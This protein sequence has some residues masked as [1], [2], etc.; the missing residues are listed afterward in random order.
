ML[1]VFPFKKVEQESLKHLLI[2]KA[3]FARLAIGSLLWWK[4]VFFGCDVLYC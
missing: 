3:G 2:L 4:Y 1:A